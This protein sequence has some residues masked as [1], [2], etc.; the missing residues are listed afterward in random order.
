MFK[1]A[2]RQ[3]LFSVSGGAAFKKR[4]APKIAAHIQGQGPIKV[5]V[6]G[7]NSRLNAWLVENLRTI[8]PLHI[9][10]TGSQRPDKY[11]KRAENE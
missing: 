3:S 5:C 10:L 6:T 11:C 2:N 9:T 7:D 4:I 1:K 8:S